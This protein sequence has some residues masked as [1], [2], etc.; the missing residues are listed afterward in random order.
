MRMMM[1]LMM[2][3]IIIIIINNLHERDLDSEEPKNHT[4]DRK[5]STGENFEE[6][7]DFF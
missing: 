4:S 1:T 2:M 3:T 6:D 7:K 5:D